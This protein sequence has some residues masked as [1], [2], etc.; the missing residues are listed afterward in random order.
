[1]KEQAKKQTKLEQVIRPGAFQ[2]PG[3]DKRSSI[4]AVSVNLVD[5][6]EGVTDP[7]IAQKL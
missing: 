7:L 2:E 1:M 3:V 6:V 5:K 4:E